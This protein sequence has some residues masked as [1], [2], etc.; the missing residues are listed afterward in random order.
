MKRW[1]TIKNNVGYFKAKVP[2]EY[3]YPSMV[4]GWLYDEKKNCLGMTAIAESRLIPVVNLTLAKVN[5]YIQQ[6]YPEIELVKG[7]GY[8]YVYSKNDAIGLKLAGLFTTTIAV[9]SLNECTI[10]RWLELVEYVLA[11]SERIAYDR[12]PV[13]TAK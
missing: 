9:Y 12:Q 11:D 1:H 8:F 4:I 5:K 6:K 10:E 7:K 3:S 2:F 13:Y